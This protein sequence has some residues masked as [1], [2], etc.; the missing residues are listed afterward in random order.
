MSALRRALI[1]DEDEAFAD[2]LA[3]ILAEAGYEVFRARDRQTAR[4]ILAEKRI[5]VVLL[6]VNHS[7]EDALDELRRIKADFPCAEVVLLNNHGQFRAAFDAMSL[8]AFDFLVKSQNLGAFVPVVDKALAQASASYRR[9]LPG[10]LS[11]PRPHG[12]PAEVVGISPEARK[13]QTLIAKIAP[14]DASVL[15]SGETGVGKELAARLIHRLSRRAAGPFIPIN[16]GA[17]PENL[18][19]NELF[20]HVRGAFTD[21]GQTKPG[22]LEEA[23]NG[24]LFLDEVTEL[25]P[26]LQAKLLRMLE[27]GGFRRLGDNKER[28]VDVRVV[29]AA[30]RNL[31]EEMRSGRMRIDFYYRLAVILVDIPP[32]RRRRED[33][34]LLVDH[35][36]QLHACAQKTAPK[37]ISR[38]AMQ[39]LAEYDWPGNVREV[40]NVVERLAVLSDG[41][42]I[43]P[44]DVEAVLDPVAPAA[45]VPVAERIGAAGA[46]RRA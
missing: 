32:L 42:T 46:L 28:H 11:C 36:F 1:F 43:A 13:L 2:D 15:V 12:A 39:M 16:C 24:T 29:A 31:A 6:G 23:D 3:D 40:R 41:E 20:G 4:R 18:L 22:L 37:K 14:T 9:K 7:R 26:A 8:G 44:A 27:T 21:S 10:G 33:I 19:E 34:P 25:S 5:L 30:N 35:F 45:G 38:G 17:I